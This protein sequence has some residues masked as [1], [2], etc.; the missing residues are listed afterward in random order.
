MKRLNRKKRH[1][2]HLY[3][4]SRKQETPIFERLEP[5]LLLDADMTGLTGGLT[6]PLNTDPSNNTVDVK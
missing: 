6:T 2:L 5:R 3:K 4:K 1:L